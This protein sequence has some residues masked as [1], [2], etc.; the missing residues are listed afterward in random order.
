MQELKCFLDKPFSANVANY[1]DHVKIATSDKE[2][3]IT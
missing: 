3:N 2:K 1:V